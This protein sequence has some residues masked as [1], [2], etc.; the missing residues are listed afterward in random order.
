[1]QVDIVSQQSIQLELTGQTGGVNSVEILPGGL[2]SGPAIT[3][4]VAALGNPSFTIDGVATNIE[5]S[6]DVV[7]SGGD[8]TALTTRV[9][10]IETTLNTLVNKKPTIPAQTGSIND[11]GPT[12][13]STVLSGAVDLDG[14]TISVVGVTYSGSARSVGTTFSTTYGSMIIRSDGTYS[15]ST[16]SVAQALKN[17]QSATEVFGYTATDGQGANVTSSLTITIIGQDNAPLAVADSG[18]VPYNTV[19]SGNVLSNDSD[20]DQGTLTLTKFVV[21]GDPTEYDAGQTATITSK[22]TISIQSNG[23]FVF[24]PENNTSGYVPAITY[25][26]SNGSL[27]QTGVLTLAISSAPINVLPDP[28]TTALTGSHAT[29]NVYSD[30]DMNALAWGSLQAGDVV[31]IHYKATPYRAKF[32]LRAQGTQ[33]SPVIIN[34][35]TDAS[36]NRPR[37]NWSTG[38]FTA[39]GCNPSGG[40]SGSNDIFSNTPDYGEGLGGLVIKRG[41]QDAYGVYVPKWIVV[42]NIHFE[43]GR[44]SYTTLSGSTANFVGTEGFGSNIYILSSES[45]TFENCISNDSGFGFFTQANGPGLAFTSKNLTVRNCR[46]YGNG[47]SGSFLEHNFY[48]Q[49]ASPTIEGNYIGQLR[50]GA[51]GSTYKSR[52]SG[53]IFRYNWVEASARAIDFVQTEDNP[54]GIPDQPDYGITWC[55]GNTIVNSNDLPLG[56]AAAPLHYGG[57]NAGEQ[58]SSSMEFVPA[59]EYRSVLYFW[60]NTYYQKSNT[61]NTYRASFF[62]LSLRGTTTYAWSNVFYCEG[63]TRFSFV[64]YAGQL[65]LLG[66]NIAHGTIYDAHD[67]AASVNY[68]VNKTGT[69]LTSDPLFTDLSTREFF[70]T[71]SSPAIDVSDAYPS[72]LPDTTIASKVL[73]YQPRKATNGLVVRVKDGSYFDLG[74]TEYGV[75]YTPAPPPVPSV[76]VLPVVSGSSVEGGQLSTTN[77]TWIGR[78]VFMYQWKRDGVN[79]SG[80]TNST[81]TT[82]SPD[83]HTNVSCTVTGT[84]SSGSSS[85]TSNAVYVVGVNAPIVSTLPAITGNPTEGLSVSCSTGTWSNSPL[86]Y[87]YQWKLNGSDI[88]GATAS[89]YTLQIGQANQQLSCTVTTTNA[90]ESN[91]AS[92]NSVTVIAAPADPDPQGT[93]N[94][95][96]ANGTTLQ[97]L[98]SDWQS[99]GSLSTQRYECLNGALQ[100][101]AGTGSNG[102]A[103][104]I[105]AGQPSTNQS[106][107]IKILSG[108]SGSFDFAIHTTGVQ[109]G[110]RLIVTTSNVTLYRAGVW[111]NAYSHGASTSN[112][113]IIKLTRNET[114]ITCLVNGSQ[115][116]SITDGTPIS[117][118]GIYFT[119]I[120]GSNVSDLR[121]DYLKTANV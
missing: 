52:S 83:Y 88:V 36:G 11:I 31:N 53:E 119:L 47:I 57:D 93:W 23:A 4:E 5:I 112:D 85:G 90:S 32:A 66:T 110:Y 55:Y 117:G 42:Q 33:L 20:P 26:I 62:D 73:T 24:T 61:A 95:S 56:T 27:T 34:G 108:W 70:L 80:A 71:Y 65:N 75:G 44:G 18:V 16:N 77:G 60:N 72:G 28:V 81:Y 121:M 79:I 21:S 14:N 39:A 8:N 101:I 67:A 103:C 64:E 7:V 76:S 58:D 92:S 82:T 46:L 113:L 69:L 97:S 22:G 19:L 50:S 102:E 109:A 94:F 87:A 6:Q 74:S 9:D 51:L 2:T 120:P 13:N 38:A 96:A 63:T 118:G 1:M 15:F 40:Y 41:P 49:A 3:V 98:S 99:V 17:G 25:T 12:R 30:A 106:A 29:Y 59:N 104:F 107:E 10:S 116:F 86:S 78:P 114:N 100:C 111:Q 48:V 115:L 84:N 89:S 105:T 68:S 45:C 35:V 91:S 43:A 37:F 54:G